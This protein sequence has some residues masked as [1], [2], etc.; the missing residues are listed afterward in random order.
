MGCSVS[1]AL[2]V[3]LPELKIMDQAAQVSTDL[4]GFKAGPHCP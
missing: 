2:A 1:P 3:H 4:R